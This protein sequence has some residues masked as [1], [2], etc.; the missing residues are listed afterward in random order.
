MTI[1]LHTPLA[2]LGLHPN[3]RNHLAR[4]WYARTKRRLPRAK[5]LA[6]PPIALRNE[7]SRRVTP[8]MVLECWYKDPAYRNGC[9]KYCPPPFVRKLLALL[10]ANGITV[11]RPC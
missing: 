10:D 11:S 8:H 9:P 7:L 1:T 3:T 2:E 5:D 6:K 4:Y